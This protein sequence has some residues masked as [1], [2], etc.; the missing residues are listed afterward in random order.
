MPPSC[1]VVS[2]ASSDT[3]P[4][5]AVLQFRQHILPALLLPLPSPLPFIQTSFCSPVE[6]QCGERYLFCLPVQMRHIQLQNAQSCWKALNT[7]H[8]FH[9]LSFTVANVLV[10]AAW[11]QQ[12]CMLYGGP[13]KDSVPAFCT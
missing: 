12:L 13:L 10:S 3:G 7:D 2:V 9:Y 11:L 1:Q 5:I 8:C 4:C 6:I